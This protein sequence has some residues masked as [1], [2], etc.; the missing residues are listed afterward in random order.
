MTSQSS[1]VAFFFREAFT[2]IYNLLDNGGDCLLLF[3]SHM[4]MYDVIRTMSKNPKWS[5]WLRNVE[6]FI[7]P[8]HDLQVRISI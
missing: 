5:P 8:Y 1:D 2:N 6:A 4:P 3:L 7:S